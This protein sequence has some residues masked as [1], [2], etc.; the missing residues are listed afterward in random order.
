MAAYKVTRQ[1]E[2]CYGH[3]LLE[4]D[5]KCRHLHGHNGLLEV[6]V[7]AQSLDRLG[8]VM[9]FG[10]VRDKV[11]GWVDANMDHRMVLRRDDPVAP[12]LQDMG[13]PLYLLDINPTAE[14]IARHIYE[15]AQSMGLPVAE[16][17]LWE[18]ST[19][20]ATYRAKA[21]L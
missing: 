7:E 13:E 3:R 6:D 11:K 14:N 1:I 16:V 17:R 10:E 9:D 15:Q 4:Y 21:A 20:Y 8:M 5:G 18:T 12:M 2:F 19:S